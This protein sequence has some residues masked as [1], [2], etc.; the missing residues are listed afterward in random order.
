MRVRAKLVSQLLQVDFQFRAC[1]STAHW[2]IHSQAQ[3]N[4]LELLAMLVFAIIYRVDQF[5]HQRIQ[6]LHRLTQRGRDEDLILVIRTAVTRPALTDVVTASAG[7][8]KPAGDHDV[9]RNQVPFGLKKWAY[10]VNC[11]KQPGLSGRMVS[12]VAHGGGFGRL[13]VW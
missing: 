1:T 8:C 7:T 6:D 13:K 3:G 4:L 5:M 9:Q 10:Q 11:S 2:A 12:H